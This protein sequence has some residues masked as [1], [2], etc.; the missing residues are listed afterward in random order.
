MGPKDGVRV[1]AGANTANCESILLGRIGYV[2]SRENSA[3]TRHVLLHNS[4]ISRQVFPEVFVYGP[5]S[6][7][8]APPGTASVE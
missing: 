4:G 2:V 5:D 8:P 7:I 3:R 1:Y 6:S